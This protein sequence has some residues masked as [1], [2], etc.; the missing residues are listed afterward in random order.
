[1]RVGTGS[2]SRPKIV[3]CTVHR[4]GCGRA[5]ISRQDEPGKRTRRSLTHSP[6]LRKFLAGEHQRVIARAT[7][8][9]T[10]LLGH[11]PSDLPS[12]AP[13]LSP[14]PIQ[15]GTGNADQVGCFGAHA[16]LPRLGAFRPKCRSR[17]PDSGADGLRAPARRT[18]PMKGATEWN[19]TTGQTPLVHY[20]IAALRM[21]GSFTPGLRASAA[22][23]HP[24]NGE[25]WTPRCP[26]GEPPPNKIANADA[27]GWGCP[28][29]AF[30][31]HCLR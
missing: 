30:D 4:T 19:I 10:A 31:L 23:Y 15:L 7:I 12:Q 11:A 27:V 2:S 6:C 25:P 21:T 26:D 18:L 17:R 3:R 13:Q 14:Q 24:A 9:L 22:N 29:C 16:R 5:S 8:G 28:S 1:M 20:L